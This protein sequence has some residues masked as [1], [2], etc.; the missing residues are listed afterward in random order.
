MGSVDRQASSVGPKPR[1]LS[2]ATECCVG[3]VFCSPTAL[4]TGTRLTWMQAKFEGP[5][6]NLRAG[7]CS[8][9]LAGCLVEDGAAWERGPQMCAE[10]GVVAMCNGGQGLVSWV[11]TAPCTDTKPSC[12]RAQLVDPH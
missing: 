4:S 9:T 12:V 2:V 5:T 6:R 8:P 7:L 3:L 1:D 11:P 10:R